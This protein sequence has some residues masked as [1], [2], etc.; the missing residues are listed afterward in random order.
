MLNCELV[1]C[2]YEG[3]VVQRDQQT[4]HRH[5]LLDDSTTHIQHN[6]YT[7]QHIYSTTHIQHNT[8]TAQHIYSTTHI[9]HNT[10]TANELTIQHNTYTAQH[11]YSKRTHNSAQ[12]I[13]SIFYILTQ[14]LNFYS[15]A[16]Y[17]IF[18]N[19]F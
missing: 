6:T 16:E 7:A 15:K 11:I 1:C 12:I 14:I 9:Q 17:F 4:Q 2:I 19:L 18:V 10:Y 3:V 13:L 8:Y 5:L